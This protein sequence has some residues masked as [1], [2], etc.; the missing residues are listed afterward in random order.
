M[1]S[2]YFSSPAPESIVT[3]E[4]ATLASY[5]M[6]SETSRGRRYP[7]S[8]HPYR[9]PFQRDRDRILHSSAFRRLAYKTQVFTGDLGDYHRNRLTHTLEVATVART[10]ARAL[11]LNEDLVESLALAHD[12]GHP[13]YGHAGE[14]ALNECLAEHGGFSHN[15]QGLRV[16]ELL[17]QRY[18]EFPGLN[19]S[20]EILDGHA[21]RI[22]KHFDAGNLI[23]VQV[24][25]AADS[26]AYDTHDAD[27]AMELGLLTLDELLKIPLWRQAREQL[28][29]SYRNLRGKTLRRALLHTLID[30]QVGDLVAQAEQGIAAHGIRSAEDAKTA[31][32]IVRASSPLLERKREL[33]QFLFDRV[34]RHPDVLRLREEAQTSLHAMF[35]GYV[36][37]PELMP[38]RFR[39]RMPSDGVERT[40]CDYLAGMTDRY[41]EREYRRLFAGKASE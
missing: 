29:E 4:R 2:T 9:G 22:D 20:A 16:L 18:P 37:R 35:A 36:Q 30:W 31:P 32:T 7:E 14:D 25:E 5:A 13:P 27:D 41:A 6:H 21:A 17:E 24:V 40:V 12:L 26:I 33:E 10:L 39:E 34:Y 19:V 23:E 38:E 28:R 8:P 1:T 3:R 11:R 15:R